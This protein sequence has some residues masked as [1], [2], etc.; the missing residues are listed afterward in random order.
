VHEVDADHHLELFTGNVVSRTEGGRRHVDL[1]GIGVGV[2]RN[3]GTV[4]AG[5]RWFHLHE[6]SSERKK[7]K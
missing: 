1:A 2:V 6:K 7:R 3:S 4:L 5:N